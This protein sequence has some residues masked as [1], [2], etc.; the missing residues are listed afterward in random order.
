MKT[1][2]EIV[3]YIREAA[4]IAGNTPNNPEE[5]LRELV[6]PIWEK[7]LKEKRVGLS[8]QICDELTLAN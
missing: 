5:K 7:F 8:L 2:S 6:S 1:L 3:N 4:R